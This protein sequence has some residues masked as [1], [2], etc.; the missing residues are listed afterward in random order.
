MVY[1]FI[2]GFFGL[3]SLYGGISYGEKMHKNGIDLTGIHDGIY[4]III[5]IIALIVRL[6]LKILKLFPYWTTKIFLFIFASICFYFSFYSFTH[7]H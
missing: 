3:L 5:D 1:G 2:S 7:L 6:L 4:D